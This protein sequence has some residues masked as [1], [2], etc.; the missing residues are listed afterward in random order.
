MKHAPLIVALLVL[1]LGGLGAYA[2]D[3]GIITVEEYKMILFALIA[4]P[5]IQTIISYFK[6]F[7]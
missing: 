7:K 4:I 6:E 3:Q 2:A 5:V 1:L